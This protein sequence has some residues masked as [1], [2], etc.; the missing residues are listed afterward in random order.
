MY[1]KINT[2]KSKKLQVMYR[3]IM[4]LKIKEWSYN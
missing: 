1:M 4:I 2:K 3:K